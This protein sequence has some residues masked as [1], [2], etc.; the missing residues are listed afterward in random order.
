MCP[1]RL[2]SELHILWGMFPPHWEPDQ[3]KENGFLH[4]ALR[5]S[6]Q[7]LQHVLSHAPDNSMNNPYH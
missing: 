4:F 1:M 2:Q 5:Q 7:A 6:L 3:L